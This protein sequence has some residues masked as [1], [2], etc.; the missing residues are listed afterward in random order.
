MMAS[1]LAEPIWGR[2]SSCSL[3]AELMSSSPS[4]AGA[5]VVAAGLAGAGAAVP[6]VDAA[7]FPVR[8]SAMKLLRLSPLSFFCPASVLHAFMRSCWAV[9]ATGRRVPV[10]VLH[11]S[12]GWLVL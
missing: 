5:V 3:D 7:G 10:A 4:C 6:A 12:A 1:A 2:A 8:Q 11:G 9:C